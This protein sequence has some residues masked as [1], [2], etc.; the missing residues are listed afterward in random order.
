MAPQPVEARPGVIANHS[1]PWSPC[2]SS[3]GG[4]G[5]VKLPPTER[6]DTIE[7]AILHQP[8]RNAASHPVHGATVRST[9]QREDPWPPGRFPYH[10]RPYRSPPRACLQSLVD[11]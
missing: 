1:R 8:G 3:E 9:P 6:L 10:P 2:P 4:R 5:E 7:D 11:L